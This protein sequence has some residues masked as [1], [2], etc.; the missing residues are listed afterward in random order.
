LQ[1]QRDNMFEFIGKDEEFDY[2]S[3]FAND[4]CRLLLKAKGFNFISNEDIEPIYNH[5]EDHVRNVYELIDSEIP[6]FALYELR[7]HGADNYGFTEVE[8]QQAILN[9][10]KACS[11]YFGPFITAQQDESKRDN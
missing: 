1:K 3:E 10:Q 2:R 6:L 4:V 11:E 5:F 8:Y 9:A 7:K